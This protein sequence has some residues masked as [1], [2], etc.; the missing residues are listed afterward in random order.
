[1]KTTLLRIARSS[2]V[3]A[4]VHI[5]KAL[6]AIP[7]LNSVKV[8]LQQGQ[9]TVEHDGADPEQLRRAFMTS[10]LPAEVVAEP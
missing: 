2:D 3:G 8:D 10:G 7:G 5:E 9:V 6:E 1:M 4:S